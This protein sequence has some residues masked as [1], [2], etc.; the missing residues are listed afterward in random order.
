LTLTLKNTGQAN[1]GQAYAK[2]QRNLCGPSGLCGSS[3][4]LEKIMSGAPRPEAGG[5]NV[6][7]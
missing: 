2:K 4:D 5:K 6:L 3:F 1:K 7:K